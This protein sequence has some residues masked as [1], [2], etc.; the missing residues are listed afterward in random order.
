MPLHG[1]VHDSP[2][3]TAVQHATRRG[4]KY[5]HYQ[6]SGQEATE[7]FVALWRKLGFKE[8]WIAEPYRKK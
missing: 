4:R 6:E 2:L 3:I 7:G 5:V 8:E 1:V